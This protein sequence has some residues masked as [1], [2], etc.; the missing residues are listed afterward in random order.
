MRW[1]ERPL[2]YDSYV[3]YPPHDEPV[4][5]RKWPKHADKV[6]ELFYKEDEE[7]GAAAALPNLQMK[8]TSELSPS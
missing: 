2:W 4:W 8:K 3:L 5:D 6:R 1:E 7:R